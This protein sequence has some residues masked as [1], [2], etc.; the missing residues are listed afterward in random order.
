MHPELGTNL[1]WNYKA[2]LEFYVQIGLWPQCSYLSFFRLTDE[3][4]LSVLFKEKTKNNAYFGELIE[5][6]HQRFI[7]LYEYRRF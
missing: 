4:F 2:E 3:H 1:L 6:K 5:I 7:F